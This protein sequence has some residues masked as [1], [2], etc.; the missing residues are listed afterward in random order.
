MTVRY[1][2]GRES[3]QLIGVSSTLVDFA[4]SSTLL[5][6]RQWIGKSWGTQL[7]GEHY[8]NPTYYRDGVEAGLFVDF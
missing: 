1:G 7:R 2:W 6:W 4:S 8:Q 5:T 3:Y